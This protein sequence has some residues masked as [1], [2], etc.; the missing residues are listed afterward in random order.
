MVNR[1]NLDFFY[2]RIKRRQKN[3]N[4]GDILKRNPKEI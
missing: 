3:N 2:K 4:K 1:N